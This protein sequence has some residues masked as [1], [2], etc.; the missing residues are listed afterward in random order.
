MRLTLM[1]LACVQ[2]MGN[3]P[4]CTVEGVA[5][6]GYIVEDAENPTHI[7]IGTGSELDLCIGAAAKLKAEGVAVRVVS[8][9]CTELFEAQSAEY[10]ESVLP[11]SVLKRVSVEAA[12]TLGWERYVG[13]QGKAMGIDRFGAS[14]PAPIIYEKFG[15]TVDGVVAAAKA[16]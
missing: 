1:R 7:L 4:G 6:G 13:F 10:K 5:K 9:P 11:M 2:G 8:M 12:A 14:A 16:L 3:H 15:L